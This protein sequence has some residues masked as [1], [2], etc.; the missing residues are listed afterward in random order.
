MRVDALPLAASGDRGGVSGCCYLGKPLS[1]VSRPRIIAMM[2]NIAQQLI[3]AVTQ[4]VVNNLNSY[5]VT[6]GGVVYTCTIANTT[7]Q[8][9][10]ANVATGTTTGFT[11]IWVIAA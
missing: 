9:K 5:A 10:S 11:T 8:E 1:L 7:V 6:A 3:T 4:S 2:L